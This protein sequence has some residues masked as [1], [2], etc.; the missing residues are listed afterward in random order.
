MTRILEL[1]VTSVKINAKNHET[2]PDTQSS[3]IYG[4]CIP[5]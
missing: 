5:V 2:N 3:R 1:C 4:Y